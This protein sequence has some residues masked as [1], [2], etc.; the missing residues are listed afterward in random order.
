MCLILEHVPSWKAQCFCA[1]CLLPAL[2]QDPSRFHRW[3]LVLE[4]SPWPLTP[5]SQSELDAIQWT[6]MTPLLLCLVIVSSSILTL[7]SV[8]TGTTFFLYPCLV[9]GSH[10]YIDGLSSGFQWGGHVCTPSRDS[11]W[12]G[13][14]IWAVTLEGLLLVPGVSRP[15]MPLHSLVPRIAPTTENCS[16][17]DVSSTGLE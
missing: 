11:W 2:S 17:W 16:A 3:P 5:T 8:S 13:G 10:I 1:V 14:M 15:G 9:Q 4:S 7:N 12:C 6:R